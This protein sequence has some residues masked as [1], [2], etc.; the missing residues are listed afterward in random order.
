MA[1]THR[2]RV[3][4]LKKYPSKT[5]SYESGD[6]TFKD[7]VCYIGA[8]IRTYDSESPDTYIE[9]DVVLD[10]ATKPQS[11]PESASDY[12]EFSDL[13]EENLV[14]I[15]KNASMYKKIETIMEDKYIR[16]WGSGAWEETDNPFD[17]DEFKDPAPSAEEMEEYAKSV[18]AESETV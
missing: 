4:K 2:W 6:V 3:S 1:I 8:R 7:Y 13:T 18:A 11:P 9:K 5:V 12:I 15:I 10:W 17:H 14:A 16:D